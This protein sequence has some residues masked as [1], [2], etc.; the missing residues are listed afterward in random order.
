MSKPARSPRTAT[1]IGYNGFNNEQFFS[2]RGRV[3]FQFSMGRGQWFATRLNPNRLAECR[4]LNIFELHPETAR[5]ILS[6]QRG[7]H[8]PR[9]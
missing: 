1:H 6:R 5:D 7:T 4:P 3:V 9:L 2:R 8:E